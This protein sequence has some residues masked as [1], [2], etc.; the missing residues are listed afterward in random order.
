MA[1][2]TATG[3][4]AAYPER[5]RA[6]G[7]DTR[8]FS[9]RMSDRI[10][11]VTYTVTGTTD[12]PDFRDKVLKLLGALLN[13]EGYKQSATTVGYIRNVHYILSLPG[14]MA[15]SA[16]HISALFKCISQ[17]RSGNGGVERW[18]DEGECEGVLKNSTDKVL[19][20][21][22][23]AAKAVSTVGHGLASVCGIMAF[24]NSIS[25]IS[26]IAIRIGSWFSAL[27]LF[28]ADL[29]GMGAAATEGALESRSAK[30]VVSKIGINVIK[31]GAKAADCAGGVITVG[32]SWG[33]SALASVPAVVKL[34]L[35][36]VA[37]LFEI[38]AACIKSAVDAP[39]KLAKTKKAEAEAA[40]K[41]AA[42]MSRPIRV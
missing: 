16:I 5:G 28:T 3:S 9:L 19:Y 31:F 41:Y 35:T 6:R 38:I 42:D 22:T 32:S 14:N 18:N 34:V 13:A 33:S 11:T 17:A 36:V 7:A 20:G 40:K 4:T 37:A 12:N 27:K 30:P 25:P 24:C 39:R 2:A 21:A 26:A 23:R 8:S 15:R 1:T 29:F 10:W